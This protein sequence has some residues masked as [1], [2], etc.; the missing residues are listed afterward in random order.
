[1][2]IYKLEDV[3]GL[4]TKIPLTYIERTNVDGIFQKSLKGEKHITVFGSSKQGK[5]CLKSIV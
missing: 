5:T 4:T 2:D 3:F 1:M